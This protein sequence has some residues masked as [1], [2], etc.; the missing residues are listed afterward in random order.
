MYNKK[1]TALYNKKLIKVSATLMLRMISIFIYYVH[2]M[3]N[4]NHHN[5]NPN[6]FAYHIL[7]LKC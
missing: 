3:K 6:I 1:K 4:L 2:I 5:K 7:G